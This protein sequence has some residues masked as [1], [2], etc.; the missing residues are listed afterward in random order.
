MRRH[1]EQQLVSC[2]AIAGAH[3]LPHPTFPSTWSGLCA[4]S[5]GGQPGPQLCLRKW[6]HEP[7]H[8]SSRS[9][10]LELFCHEK[11]WPGGQLQDLK[12]STFDMKACFKRFLKQGLSSCFQK[13][14]TRCTLSIT[15]HHDSRV[16]PHSDLSQI[17]S[18]QCACIQIFRPHIA[19]SRIISLRRGIQSILTQGRSFL[20]HENCF[21]RVY[22]SQIFGGENCRGFADLCLAYVKSDTLVTLFHLHTKTILLDS[23][24]LSAVCGA[25]LCEHYR[26]K[27]FLVMSYVLKNKRLWIPLPCL[28]F[29][30]DDLRDDNVGHGLPNFSHKQITCPDCSFLSSVY[31]ARPRRR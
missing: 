27:Q 19:F 1:P 30:D 22:F 25:S 9:I 12:A 23:S 15:G 6:K 28:Y 18:V 16:S 2:N 4:S 13:V 26:R 17:I 29:A 24:S 31:G 7:A 21:C 5:C 10:I 11:V 14:Y 20:G 8:S 3:I